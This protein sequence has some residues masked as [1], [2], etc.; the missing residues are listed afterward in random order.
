MLSILALCKR[1]KLP[2]NIV[3]RVKAV[4]GKVGDTQQKRNRILHDSWYMTDDDQASTHQFRAMPKE[5]HTF[6][7]VPKDEAYLKQTL[8][9][10]SQR[11]N[12]VG[13]LSQAINAAL[14]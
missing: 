8:N 7:F 12:D 5:D 3:D 6:G 14:A 2:K 9:E 11:M 1:C 4:S 10:I 13:E